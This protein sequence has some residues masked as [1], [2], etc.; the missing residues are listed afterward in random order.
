MPWIEVVPGIYH[1]SA[2]ETLPPALQAVRDRALQSQQEERRVS[3][4]DLAA[5]IAISGLPLATRRTHRF[6][7]WLGDGRLAEAFE[8]AQTF[9]SGQ[10]EHPFLTL[11]G[12]PG[13]GKTHLALAIS[14][15]WLERC[16]RK[17]CYWQVEAF[18]DSLRRGY[19]ADRAEHG[20]QTHLTVD[21]AK[22][23]CSLLVL[24][25]LGA[26]RVTDWSSAR[27]DEI[28]DFRYVNRLATVFTLNVSAD[29]LAPRLADRLFEGKVL[30]LDAPSYR[31]RKRQDA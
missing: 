9:A 17:V 21:Y 15:D 8:H 11:A 13:T 27:L 10:I 12:P 26:E 22:K 28:V 14:W 18:L 19:A 23:Y 7:Q 4:E 24:D 31:R 2:D 30:V 5:L 20:S 3:D 1:G 16:H 6:S 25:D 29:E